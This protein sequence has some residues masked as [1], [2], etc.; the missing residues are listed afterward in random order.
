VQATAFS[1]GN[2]GAV[3]YLAFLP[4]INTVSQVTDRE[5]GRTE[6]DAVQYFAEHCGKQEDEFRLR[7][8]IHTHPAYKAFMSGLDLC[9]MYYLRCQNP[10]S[11]AIVLS[12]RKKG[13]KALCVHLTDAGFAKLNTYWQM[14]NSSP[15][16]SQRRFFQIRIFTHP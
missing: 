4:Q 12:P 5:G 1:Y 9:Q 6:Y 11:F 13:V 3:S 15:L 14:T 7:C 16:T 10:D 8:W 2:D